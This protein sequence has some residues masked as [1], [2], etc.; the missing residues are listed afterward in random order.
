MESPLGVKNEKGAGRKRRKKAFQVHPTPSHEEPVPGR[1]YTPEILEFLRSAH[2][3]IRIDGNGDYY[4]ENV[5]TI[6]LHFLLRSQLPAK[7]MLWGWYEH[8]ERGLCE[9][10]YQTLP[11]QRDEEFLD[12]LSACAFS[13]DMEAVRQSGLVFLSAHRKEVYMGLEEFLTMRLDAYETLGDDE[14]AQIL[15]PKGTWSDLHLRKLVRQIQTQPLRA[16]QRRAIYDELESDYLR[17]T[18]RHLLDEALSEAFWKA[19]PPELDALRSRFIIFARTM[20]N[21]A[22]RLGVYSSR[23]SFEQDASGQ[24]E[25]QSRSSRQRA[26]F[27]GNGGTSGNGGGAN[28]QVEQTHFTAL[29]LEP[30]ASLLEVKNA[31]RDR[32]KQHHPDQGGT[33]QDFLRLQEAYEYLLTQVF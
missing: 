15:T 14:L 30:G 11:P 6:S 8:F 20:A 28:R 12:V 4:Y 7:E 1:D 10:I 9:T 17:A 29:G 32:V 25:R 19:P 26:G 22:R 16:D 3:K 23:K 27:H 2:G 5:S 18:A 24:W 31:Y 13:W 33:V 21:T